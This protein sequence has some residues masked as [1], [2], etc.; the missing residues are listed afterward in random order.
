MEDVYKEH[1]PEISMVLPPGKSSGNFITPLA[2]SKGGTWEHLIHSVRHLLSHLL[3]DPQTV[4]VSTD[5]LCMMLARAQKVINARPLTP[6]RVSSEDCDVIT[7]SSLLHHHSIRP[8]NLNGTLP[9]RE[10]LL[11]DHRHVQER[12]DVFWE[13]WVLLY[14]HYLQ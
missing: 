8:M 11:R 5:V 9:T 2:S 3:L 10:S 1:T 7:P 14:L 6:V 13:R 12:V 4:P